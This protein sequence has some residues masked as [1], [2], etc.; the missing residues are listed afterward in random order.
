M[1]PPPQPSGLQ[2]GLPFIVEANWSAEQALAAF[3]LLTDLRDTIWR[4]YRIPIQDL[5]R[6]QRRPAGPPADASNAGADDPPF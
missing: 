4:H 6:E 2:R 5:L 3:E 1:K